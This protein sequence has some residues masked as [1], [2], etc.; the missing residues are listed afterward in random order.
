M[1][2]TQQLLTPWNAA[3]RPPRCPGGW[4]VALV[5]ACAGLTSSFAAEAPQVPPLT[6]GPGGLRRAGKFVWADLVTDG[7]AMA[8]RLYARLFGWTFQDL[9]DYT[10]GANDER[11]VCG[12]LQKW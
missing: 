5:A 9:G 8:R 12:M 6:T 2:G 10:T 7:V 11:P 4:L 3:L 1:I